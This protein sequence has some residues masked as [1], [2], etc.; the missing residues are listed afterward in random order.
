L[1]WL[2]YRATSNI[3]YR[4]L[5]VYNSGHPKQEAFWRD[6]SPTTYIIIVSWWQLYQTNLPMVRMLTYT[7]SLA[8]RY[9]ISMHRSLCLSCSNFCEHNIPPIT[10]LLLPTPFQQA[11]RQA[12]LL[13][14]P[15]LITDNSHS[16]TEQA[17]ESSKSINIKLFQPVLITTVRSYIWWRGCMY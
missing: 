8:C 12:P 16:A 17:H 5:T 4:D 2:P 10:L 14:P 13:P 7:C 3:L 15:P 11:S 9:M 1:F 6:S